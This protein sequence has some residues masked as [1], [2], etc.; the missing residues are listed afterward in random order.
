M[1]DPYKRAKWIVEQSAK[2]QAN[3]DVKELPLHRIPE[4]TDPMLVV[5]TTPILREWIRGRKGIIIFNQLD[6]R[7]YRA[8][9]QNEKIEL[10][11]YWIQCYL[12]RVTDGL[13][14][15]LAKGI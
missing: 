14:D 5:N 9:T 13:K 10:Q 11:E 12:T 1:A 4:G 6:Q 15:R 2:K 7:D 8:L 3:G